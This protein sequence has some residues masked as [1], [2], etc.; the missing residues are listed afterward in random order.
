MNSEITK[1]HAVFF[2]ISLEAGINPHDIEALQRFVCLFSGAE[3]NIVILITRSETLTKEERETKV[4]ELKSHP[5]LSTLFDLVGGKV[6]FTG[7]IEKRLF[8]K[9]FYDEFEDTLETVNSMRAALFDYIFNLQHSFSLGTLGIVDAIRAKTQII[10]EKL[11]TRMT[12]NSNIVDD[13]DYDELKNQLGEISER[14][15]LLPASE[16]Q[17]VR[18]LINDWTPILDNYTK[19]IESRSIV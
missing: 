3:K 2:V 12:Q 13:N 10:V 18:S 4:K 6:F 16:Q 7:T 15:P 17:K 19:R 9:G 8:E 1:I 5:Q 11:K 14:E